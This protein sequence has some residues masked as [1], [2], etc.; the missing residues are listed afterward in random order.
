M[1]HLCSR[2]SIH[3]TTFIFCA[4]HHLELCSTCQTQTQVVCLRFRSHHLALSHKER[5][6]TSS[7]FV[8][9][10]TD[11]R[12][13]LI[14]TACSSRSLQSGTQA[15]NDRRDHSREESGR[16]SEVQPLANKNS[17]SSLDGQALCDVRELRQNREGCMCVCVCVYEGTL[18][19]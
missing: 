10:I 4:H 18:L 6:N 8:H 16:N 1:L 13:D 17:I 12:T 7:L 15:G 19:C 11:W 3:S 14:I 2:P 5:S 9:D